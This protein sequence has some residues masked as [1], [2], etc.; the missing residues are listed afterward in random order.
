MLAN[1]DVTQSDSDRLTRSRHSRL[2]R[3]AQWSVL[4]ARRSGASTVT[5]PIARGGM[6][7]VYSAVDQE[8]HRTVAIKFLTASNLGGSDETRRVLREARAA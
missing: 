5:Q 3:P 4:P 1:A 2:P 8:L 7:E 6:G